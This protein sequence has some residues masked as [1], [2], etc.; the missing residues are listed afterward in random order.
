MKRLL[1]PLLAALA[2][3]TAVNAGIDPKVH[4]LCKDVSDYRGCVKANSNNKSWNIF[5]KKN[6]SKNYKEVNMHG[7]LYRKFP[8]GR[9]FVMGIFTASPAEKSGLKYG[10][11]ITHINGEF[12][13]KEPITKIRGLIDK[14]TLELKVKRYFRIENSKIPGKNVE[15]FKLS[16]K[17]FKVSINEYDALLNP[18]REKAKEKWTKFKR[19]ISPEYFVHKGKTYFASEACPSNKNM[20]WA[21]TGFLGRKVEELGCMSRDEKKFAELDLKIKKLNQK[22]RSNTFFN[23]SNSINNLK[24]RQNSA[25]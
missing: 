1:L 21:T 13:Y 23:L 16:R 19:N 17:K 14:T 2:L 22:V 7:F 15:E 11:E 9:Y 3:P 6:I 4:D 18:N 24:M 5:K 12:I 8:D 10:D 25:Y 20:V